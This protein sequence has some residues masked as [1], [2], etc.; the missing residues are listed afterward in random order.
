MI[1]G[2]SIIFKKKEKIYMYRRIKI[3]LG[4]SNPNPDCI[5]KMVKLE[6]EDT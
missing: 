4:D 5:K 2:L 3:C 6:L 1:K